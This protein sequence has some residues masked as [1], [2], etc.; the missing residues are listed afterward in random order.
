MVPVILG[1]WLSV[2]VSL[3][4]SPPPA[5]VH[6]LVESQFNYLSSVRTTTIET[7]S[8]QGKT[9]TKI[10]DRLTIR[11]EDLGVRWRVDLKAG[12]YTE[13]KIAPPAAAEP[14]KAVG[15]T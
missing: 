11:R 5:D 13:E 9:A 3:P 6:L 15:R 2:A 10:G 4:V 8:A 1:I 12:T 7:W 14:A